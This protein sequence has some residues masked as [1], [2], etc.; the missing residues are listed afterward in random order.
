MTAPTSPALT[1][2]DLRGDPRRVRRE[3]V[4]RTLLFAAALTSIVISA[5]I[6]FSLVREAW[7]FVSTVE[8][9]HLWDFGW[10]P[11]RGNFDVRT[12]IVGS[13]IVTV[14]A[15]AVAGPI[16]L[17]TAIYL[18][19]YAKPRVR[20]TLKP[21]IEVLAG[22]PSVVV[23][24]FALTVISP[25][26]VQT[27]QPDAPQFNLLAAGIGVGILTIPLVA[28]VSEDALRPVPMSLREASYGLGAR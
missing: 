1:V 5:L 10:Y 24:Y 14:I 7:A 23:G 8:V 12:L 4:I 9:A 3:G 18:S 26:V 11:R 16:G 17:G 19:E 27:M 21:I 2:A 15:M 28:P 25:D 13:L 6:V 22:I 20:R